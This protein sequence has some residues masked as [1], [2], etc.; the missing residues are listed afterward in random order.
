MWLVPIEVTFYRGVMSES[1][2]VTE[3]AEHREYRLA[4]R[5]WLEANAELK[6]GVD[7]WSTQKTHVDPEALV[8][9]FE[10]CKAWQ[11]TTAEGGYA[12]ITWDKAHGGQG[13]ESWQASIYNEEAAAFDVTNGFLAATNAMLGT[14]LRF[15]G[16]EDQKL[17]YLP[18][19]VRA[20][21][22]W[23]QLFSEP[24]AGSDLAGLG[25][26]AERDGDIFRLNGQKV[27]NSMAQ[28]ADW[29]F[30]LVRSNPDA[31]KH[32][33]ITFILVDMSSPGIEVRPL[34]QPNGQAHFNEVFFDDV[35]VPVANVVGEIDA[36]WSV[37]KTVLMAE[38]Q[39]IG[40]SGGREASAV[41]IDL[42]QRRGVSDDPV[43]RQQLAQAVI[44]DRI[45]RLLSQVLMDALRSG[46]PAPIDG[47]LLKLK[48]AYN[49]VG[50]GNTAMAIMGPEGLVEVG[51]DSTFAMEELIG[52]FHVSIGGG[53][54]EVGKNNIGHRMGLPREPGVAID[55][56]WKD[57][58]R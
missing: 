18:P 55:T 54:N 51:P 52:R 6:T 48:L 38:S 9:Y 49:R 40:T 5:A 43:V 15:H 3:P 1:Q 57:I 39:F 28:A 53:T 27:W 25:C 8:A 33:G 45:L 29:G 30:M 24:G 31:P 21:Q 2:G 10:R 50:L 35:D 13:G 20:D 23:C 26:R 7:D 34:V 47:A 56:P 42:A 4:A 11:K 44:N 41:L 17:T 58:P 46:K 12:S 19:M 36:G 16:T 14:A 32:K 22:T 37:A